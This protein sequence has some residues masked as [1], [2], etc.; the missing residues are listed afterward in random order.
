VSGVPN[1]YLKSLPAQIPSFIFLNQAQ[2]VPFPPTLISA[3]KLKHFS[4]RNNIFFIL[5]H[6]FFLKHFYIF[7]DV[8]KLFIFLIVF[9]S[10]HFK[11]HFVWHFE[12]DRRESKIGGLIRLLILN[13]IKILFISQDFKL[14]RDFREIFFF[15]D[16][17]LGLKRNFI[18]FRG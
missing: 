8:F 1:K 18:Q 16:F 7:Y 17:F 10:F 11:S 12:F 14:Y 5:F 9:F 2:A 15:H 3:L 4:L 6:C 13:K